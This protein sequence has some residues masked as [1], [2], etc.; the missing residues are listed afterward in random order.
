MLLASLIVKPTTRAELPELAWGTPSMRSSVFVNSLPARG[1][2]RS[3]T[4]S[5]SPSWV[6]TTTP[7]TLAIA[8]VRV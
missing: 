3:S 8:W 2:P 4:L 5:K 1:S 6:L 7:G